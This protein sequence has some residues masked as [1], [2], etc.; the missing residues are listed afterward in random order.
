MIPAPAPLPSQDAAAPRTVGPTGGGADAEEG[1]NHESRGRGITSQ[2]AV[3]AAQQ[4][5]LFPCPG[6]RE[7]SRCSLVLFP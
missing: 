4:V 2:E 3:E 6:E 1:W 5:P 7:S